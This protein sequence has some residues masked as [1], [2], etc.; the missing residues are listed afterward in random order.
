[1]SCFPKV[2]EVVN[3][4]L[5]SKFQESDPST[6]AVEAGGAHVGPVWSWEGCLPPGPGPDPS[7]AP[8]WWVWHS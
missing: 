8:L 2:T 7:P 1:M 4:K 6:H 5:G 3:A